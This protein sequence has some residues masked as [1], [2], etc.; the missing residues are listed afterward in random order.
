MKKADRKPQRQD[1]LADQMKT[2]Y[3]KAVEIGCYDAADWIMERWAEN[4]GVI[5]SARRR[6]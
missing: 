2:V 5:S 3:R 1:S 4:R 6:G